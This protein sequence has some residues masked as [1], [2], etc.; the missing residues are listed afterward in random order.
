MTNYIEAAHIIPGSLQANHGEIV[1]DR[2]ANIWVNLRRYFPVLR[3]MEF[4]SQLINWENNVLM[5]GPQL[6]RKFGQF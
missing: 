1:E 5:L 6:H 4:T 3:S 2:H